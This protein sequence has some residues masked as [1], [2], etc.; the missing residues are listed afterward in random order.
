[1]KQ[2]SLAETGFLPKVG[3]Q[4]RPQDS[5][6]GGDGNAGSVVA[7]CGA[8]R[9]VLSEAGRRCRWARCCGF[10]SCSSGLASEAPVWFC[11]GSLPWSGEE[12]GADR[13]AVC[14]GQFVDGSQ[15]IVALAGRGAPVKREMPSP[16]FHVQWSKIACFSS[17]YDSLCGNG[18][19]FRESIANG[20]ANI[21]MNK[22]MNKTTNPI[23]QNATKSDAR[24]QMGLAFHQTGSLE[25][26]ETMYR[27]AIELFQGNYYSLYMLA[28]IAKSNRQHD[29]ALE[30][31][32]QA[33]N[34]S[35][36]D[37]IFYYNLAM[38][39]ISVG[40]ISAALKYLDKAVELAPEY[41]PAHHKRAEI[42]MNENLPS[43][44][45][46]SYNIIIKNESKNGMAYFNRSVA[47]EALEQYENALS[48][49]NSAIEL[50]PKTAELFFN[51][52]NLLMHLGRHSEAIL[53]YDNAIELRNEY[54]A[55]YNNRGFSY[56]QIN[57]HAEAYKN[58]QRSIELNPDN[59]SAYRSLGI[60]LKILK[61]TEG[62]LASFEKAINIMPD[63][64]AAHN[65]KGLLLGE[66]G[67]Y[68][69]AL[70]AYNKA[71]D[72][73]PNFPEAYTNRGCILRKLNRESEALDS[74]RTA[75][76]LRPDKALFHYNLGIVEQEFGYWHA[77]IESYT[78]ATQADPNSVDAHWNKALLLLLTGNWPSGWL[79]HEWRWKKDTF[80]SPR[81]G[82]TQPLW[83][84]EF[85]I[86]GKT[87]LLHREQG[88][89]DALQFC[90]YVPLVKQLG[91][92]IILEVPKTL[93]G[94]LSKLEGIDEIVEQFKP[95]PTFDVHCPL[96][97]LPLAFNTTLETVPFPKG[98]LVAEASHVTRWEELLG[99]T[100]RPRVGIAW[101]GNPKHQNDTIRSLAL[102][103]LLPFLPPDFD[104]Y[105]LQKD[106][107][108]ADIVV[109]RDQ[110]N[111]RRFESEIQD[112]SDTAALCTLMDLVISVDT[113]IAH[114]SGALGKATWILI[115]TP[116]EWRWLAD[117][118]DTV[119]YES[120][121][122]YR[123]PSEGDWQSLLAQIEKDLR[124]NLI[125]Q[126]L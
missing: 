25:Q 57:R 108:E 51:Q 106:V 66:I 125:T 9:A 79:F 71:I 70:D 95:L 33:E 61:Q 91:A 26:A 17:F 37:P 22:Y 59:A 48:D 110:P 41:L 31:F 78:K 13:D 45:L 50:L 73:Q 100:N 80:T 89:G 10:T 16:G 88:L 76:Q 118:T 43:S 111:I 113:S 86:K 121:R 81:R 98:Y 63:Y 109:L 12:Y 102:H 21:Y 117:R 103:Q 75:V 46:S 38:A 14:A 36:V 4:T 85:S 56:L 69:L 24:F 52:G 92:R 68:E 28:S 107:R 87:I 122:L 7:S 3:K 72:L 116:P 30:L 120:V 49:I 35:I 47:H 29:L 105:V 114:L 8:D 34:Q 54:A 58:F 53:C 27:E 60:L 15:A 97:S 112:F 2:L 126:S 84:G 123:Q 11:E 101:S 20:S 83:L 96:M 119:W 39:N 5:V 104:Y 42:L 67:Q 74:C 93:I 55:A 44:A 99:K 1:M 23:S 65:D 40:D 62:A 6:H 19:L 18:R 64:A 77:A 90:R 82:F 32:T 124:Q 115:H 94:L